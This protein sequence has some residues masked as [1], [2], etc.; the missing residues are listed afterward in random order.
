MDFTIITASYNYGHY[1]AE[2]M[3]SVASQEGVTFEHL[4][5]DA[6]STDDTPEVVAK[7]QHASFFQEPDKGM[8]DGIN[9]GF[10]KAKG[11]WVMWL[12]ADDRMLPGALKAVKGHAETHHNA[13]VI[14]GCWNFIDTNGKHQRTMT[15]FPFVRSMLPNHYCYIASTS[16]YF[17]RETTIEEGFLLDI[18]FRVVMDGEYYCRL[19]YAGKK[20]SYLPRILA[21]F[22][23]HD[24]SISQRNL[25]KND[26]AGILAY[27]RQVAES[28]AIRRMYGIKLFKDEMAN[29]I[30]DGLLFHGYRVLKGVLKVIYRG[31]TIK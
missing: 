28:R 25:G 9:K 5:M 1:V 4:V 7:F 21:D 16:T 23:L 6:G 17:R 15:L 13:D 24:Q 8:S 10:L 14:Y 18:D 19:A 31:K 2:C 26:M 29:S 22:R 3:E 30:V 27:Q 12:N 20:F 11:K